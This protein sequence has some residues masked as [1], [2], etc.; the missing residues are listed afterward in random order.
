ML[1]K[2]NNSHLI[3]DTP[4]KHPLPRNQQPHIPHSIVQKDEKAIFNEVVLAFFIDVVC[5][6]DKT[7]TNNICRSL[8]IRGLAN[9]KLSWVKSALSL[10]TI[11]SVI[12]EYRRKIRVSRGCHQCSY[13]SYLLWNLKRPSFTKA[14]RRLVSAQHMLIMKW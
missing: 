9:Q 2:I 6:I 5:V 12:R 8:Q 4:M 3:G 7:G 14:G 13:R 1:E 10:R 11:D